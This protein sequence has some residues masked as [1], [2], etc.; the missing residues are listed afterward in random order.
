MLNLERF[1]TVA[2]PLHLHGDGCPVGTEAAD[3]TPRS[4]MCESAGRC[5][6]EAPLP[7][8]CRTVGKWFNCC[9]AYLTEK[10]TWA[11]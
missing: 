7:P 10:H 11:S 3:G 2:L 4:L 9:A 1:I 8:A 6:P 5:A